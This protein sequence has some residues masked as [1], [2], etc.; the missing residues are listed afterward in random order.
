LLDCD[1][2]GVPNGIEDNL[3]SDK[4]NPLSTPEHAA[5]GASCFDGIDNDLDGKIDWQQDEGCAGIIF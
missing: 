5:W 2:D 1:G 3:G 4:T